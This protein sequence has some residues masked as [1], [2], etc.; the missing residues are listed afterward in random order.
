MILQVDTHAVSKYTETLKRLHRSAFPNAIRGTLNKAAFDVKQNT[1]PRSA[2]RTFVNRQPNFLKANSSV[3]MASGFNVSSMKSIVGFNEAN[4]K[5]NHFAVR[6]LEQQERGGT[7]ASRSFIPTTLARGG[8]NAKPVR[9][10]N[11]LSSIKKIV[12]AD[13][14]KGKNSHERFTKS[15]IHAGKGGYV[16][17]DGMLWRINSTKRVKVKVIGRYSATKVNSTPVY[18]FAEGRKVNIASKNFMRKATLETVK[19]MD[20]FYIQEAKRQ[21]EKFAVR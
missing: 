2:T 3:E 5:G 15:A 9:P 16:I 12:N 20:D 7:I 13:N 10:G 8:S 11:R 4:A 6:E 1:M 14:A 21:F 19:R 18:S 17:S